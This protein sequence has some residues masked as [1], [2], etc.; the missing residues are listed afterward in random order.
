MGISDDRHMWH[1]LV[2]KKPKKND[3]GMYTLKVISKKKEEVVQ[4]NL[5]CGPSKAKANDIVLGK[6]AVPKQEESTE[7]VDIWVKLKNANTREY[8]GIAF[9][10]GIPDLKAML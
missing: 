1:K 9:K 8:D 4:F 2:F 3:S 10:H 7:D 5:N 6:G